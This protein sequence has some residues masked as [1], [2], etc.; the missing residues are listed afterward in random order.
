MSLEKK[1]S[2]GNINSLC[3]RVKNILRATDISA[4]N[5]ESQITME[6][7]SSRVSEKVDLTYFSV[8]DSYSLD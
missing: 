7:N 4:K 6:H 5:L 3:S 1:N 8:F 2:S